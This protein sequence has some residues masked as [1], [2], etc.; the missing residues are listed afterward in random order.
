MMLAMTAGADNI[1]PGELPAWQESAQV[2]AGW[3]FAT[4]PPDNI[5]GGVP[6]GDLL[7]DPWNRLIDEP[8]GNLEEM[9]QWTYWA[10][11]IWG[12]P[13]TAEWLI[14]LVNVDNIHNPYKRIWL[15]FVYT[16]AVN[17]SPAYVTSVLGPPSLEIDDRVVSQ[18]TETVQ[19]EGNTYWR[20]TVEYEL[21]PNPHW[22]AIVIGLPQDDPSNPDR[23]L[24]EVYIMT[25]CVPEPA[26][27]TVLGIGLAG[28]A[29]RRFRQR[30]QG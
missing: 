16:P 18:Y 20:T 4:P 24:H 6:V 15:S 11:P 25:E 28:F 23:F 2:Q 30:F 14:Y 22:E 29:V 10:P 3:T 21:R 9:N 27:M 7:G 19:S 13:D 17:E 5:V 26:T 12:E 8:R 1:W